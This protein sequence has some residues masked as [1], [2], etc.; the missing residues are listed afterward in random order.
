MAAVD[1][2]GSGRLDGEEIY[3]A[4]L[5]IYIYVNAV[6]K[7]KSSSINNPTLTRFFG[8]NLYVST[9]QDHHSTHHLDKKS[10]SYSCWPPF[11]LPPSPSFPLWHALDALHILACNEV[12]MK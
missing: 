8:I 7:C 4:V 2:D 11:L 12:G 5:K 1:E 6:R 3:I 10:T 9:C